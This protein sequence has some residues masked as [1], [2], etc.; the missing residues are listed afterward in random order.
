[1]TDENKV[2]VKEEVQVQANEQ[3][4]AQEPKTTEA[5]SNSEKTVDTNKQ[6]EQ[7]KSESAHESKQDKRVPL[8]E[9]IKERQRRR[10]LE[11]KLEELESK[12]NANQKDPKVTELMNDL[13]L[14]ED[15]AVKLAKHI[16]PK[17]EMK[18]LE[19]KFRRKAE[20]I[21][22]DY[23]DWFELQQ[24]MAEEFNKVYSRNPKL[25]LSESP[26]KFY[27]MAKNRRQ[28][29]PEKIRQEGARD[30]I[31]K[32]NSKNLAT[33]ESAKNGT[34]KV[35]DAKPRKFTRA[36]LKSLSED[37]FKKY[38]NEINAELLRGGFKE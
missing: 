20:D 4:Q 3:A 1:M 32:V 26:E 33:T 8:P 5:S 18:E 21:S 25:A 11:K 12:I 27:Y 36:W 2:D 24:D 14:D 15:T 6:P 30:A 19:E 17:D 23:E 9:L 28:Q 10:E 38:H 7:P 29:D 35:E 34:V 22:G 31:N 16:A 37:D 13:N